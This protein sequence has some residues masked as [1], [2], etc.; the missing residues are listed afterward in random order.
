MIYT[1]EHARILRNAIRTKPVQAYEKIFHSTAP[2]WL[3][4]LL[5]ALFVKHVKKITLT[6][7]FS[8]GKT[9]E[10]PRIVMLWVWAYGPE[11]IV[12]VGAPKAEQTKDHFWKEF[13]RM[14]TEY[15][16]AIGGEL[17]ETGEWRSGAPMCYIKTMVPGQRTG[18]TGKTAFTGFGT[19]AEF[20]LGILDDGQGID[21]P[22]FDAYD[23]ATSTGSSCLLVAG[24]PV[25]QGGPLWNFTDDPKCLHIS[26]SALEHPNV[27]AWMEGKDPPIPSAINPEYV[28]DKVFKHCRAL[29]E[30]VERSA[31]AF[32]W[33][34]QPG[35]LDETGQPYPMIFFE[36][37]AWFIGNILGQFPDISKSS[38]VSYADA[39]AAAK[40][41]VHRIGEPV[42]CG[43][44]PA[45]WGIDETVFDLR[46]LTEEGL[47]SHVQLIYPGRNE[48]PDIIGYA[49]QLL[50][51]YPGMR[52]YGD[53]IGVGSGV[54]GVLVREFPDRA[55]GVKWS[56]KAAIGIDVETER[57]ASMRFYDFK[58][59]LHFA[60]AEKFKAAMIAIEDD[61]ELVSEITSSEH[62]ISADGRQCIVSKT[63]RKQEAGLS[64]PNRWEAL[65]LSYAGDLLMLTGEV[66]RTAGQPFRAAVDVLQGVDTA[67][68]SGETEGFRVSREPLTRVDAR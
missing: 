8:T 15:A 2:A 59:Q 54:M 41:M 60:V 46:Y 65:L 18:P 3:A 53:A 7:G 36:P 19:H 21:Q 4:K 40:Q 16:D 6:G 25:Y 17:L 49:K 45:E 22:Q 63:L 52:L 1:K 20:V 43:L 57:P 30:G 50:L 12:P 62:G 13:R 38:L 51:R 29:P 35:R 9:Y 28:D 5:I 68:T 47:E 23:N 58:T 34:A 39:D 26:I 42:T 10:L 31:H 33:Y 64:S 67:R 11:A 44:D 61:R 56:P 27:L 14:Y 55:L 66:P 32:R 48:A 37:D 24:N